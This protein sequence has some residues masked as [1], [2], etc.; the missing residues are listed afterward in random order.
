MPS[1]EDLYM[2]FCWDERLVL[3]SKSIILVDEALTRS[4][5]RNNRKVIRCGLH[6]HYSK[7]FRDDRYIYLYLKLS[8]KV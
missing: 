6:T 3:Y 4:Y 1:L 8:R 7:P 2:V 5:P